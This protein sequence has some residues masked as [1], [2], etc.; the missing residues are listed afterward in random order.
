MMNCKDIV[1]KI[2]PPIKQI[3]PPLTTFTI[4]MQRR[5]SELVKETYFAMLCISL[6][7]IIGGEY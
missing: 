2:N 5:R 4:R 1:N 7:M 3:Y 6:Q